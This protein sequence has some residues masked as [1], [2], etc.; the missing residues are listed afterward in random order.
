MFAHEGGNN[1]PLSMLTNNREYN[2][3]VF[4]T[5]KRI[6]INYVR[7]GK[8]LPR[9]KGCFLLKKEQIKKSDKIEYIAI[10]A[11]TRC[12]S[13]CIYCPTHRNKQYYNSLSDISILPFIKKIIDKK[14]L[15][16]NCHVEFGGG[17]PVLH[18]EFEE[19]LNLMIDYGITGYK[20]HSSGIKYS[21]AIE[22]CLKF[23]KS[24]I[25]ISIDSGN[26]TTYK[27]IKNTDKFDTVWQNTGNY[28]VAQNNNKEQVQV[29]YILI[30]GI[31]DNINEII[32]FFKQII[33]YNVQI[34][35]I[36]IETF[37]YKKNNKNIK[38]VEKMFKYVK[39]FEHISK[40]IGIK[41]GHYATFCCAVNDYHKMY[42]DCENLIDD[43]EINELCKKIRL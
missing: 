17:E 34:V 33:K 37:W 38:E 42:D 13:D 24:E 10:S 21:N 18:K 14:I 32:D 36:D 3:D 26:K 43:N 16:K 40:N 39:I 27:Q 28:V 2:Y 22:K 25:V 7:K 5:R 12:N 20:I 19:V 6:E 35:L 29:K 15:S 31:N 41:S 8:L 30:P 9:C 11:N 4:F 1:E 23:D